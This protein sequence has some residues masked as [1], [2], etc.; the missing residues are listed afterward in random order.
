MYHRPKT[1]EE[2]KLEEID[3]LKEIA[4]EQRSARTK[5][6]ARI[7]LRHKGPYLQECLRQLITLPRVVDELAEQGIDV[8]VASL[9]KFMI[10]FLPGD[11]AEYLQITGRGM[12]KNRAGQPEQPTPAPQVESTKKKEATPEPTSEKQ[13]GANNKEEATQPSTEQVEAN[14]ATTLD[15]AAAATPRKFFDK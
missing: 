5:G 7:A 8:S 1:A 3:R 12:K 14:K 13:V 4:L 15:F 6:H 2:L 10:E 11:Y 9:R